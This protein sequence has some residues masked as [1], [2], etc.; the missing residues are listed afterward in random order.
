M[1]TIKAGDIAICQHFVFF[2]EYN[3]QEC[4]VLD[5]L[6]FRDSING[7]TM[8]KSIRM[9]YRVKLRD[10]MILGPFAHQ[11][12]VKPSTDDSDGIAANDELY[13]TDAIA[14]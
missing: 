13:T 7:D 9:R 10:G 12:R 1:K 4:E 3:G 8:E 6:E 14:A 5:G 2:P 11:L